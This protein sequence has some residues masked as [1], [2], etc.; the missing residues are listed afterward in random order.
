[1]SD[2]DPRLLEYALGRLTPGENASLEEELAT[3][4]A[5]REALREVQLLI[6]ALDDRHPPVP[7]RLAARA[8]LL[9][10]AQDTSTR[11]GA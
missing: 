11:R 1:M 7:P 8:R 10:P 2:H 3:T 9:R 6:E 5:L 4:P